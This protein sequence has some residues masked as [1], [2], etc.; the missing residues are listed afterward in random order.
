MLIFR[1]LGDKVMIIPDFR[2]LN[3]RLVKLNASIP[4]VRDAIQIMG[5]SEV[6]VLLVPDLKDVCHTLQLANES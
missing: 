4:S 1:N 5:E 2:H 6:E 3:S